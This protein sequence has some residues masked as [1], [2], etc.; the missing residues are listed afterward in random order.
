MSNWSPVKLL[1][2]FTIKDAKEPQGSQEADISTIHSQRA[3]IDIMQVG[4]SSTFKETQAKCIKHSKPYHSSFV[5]QP[6]NL[7][8]HHQTYLEL[9]Y[10]MQVKMA[11]RW[12]GLYAIVSKQQKMYII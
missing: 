4:A 6:G 12:T 10:S 8:L 2:G 1:F 5:Y 9:T 7:V 3:F 11:P